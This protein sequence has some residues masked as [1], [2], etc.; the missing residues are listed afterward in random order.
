MMI[1]LL[2]WIGL[3]WTRLWMKALLLVRIKIGCQ[4]W[5]SMGVLMRFLVRIT[6]LSYV[7]AIYLGLTCWHPKREI[8]MLSMRV[9]LF[10]QYLL[11]VLQMF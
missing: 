8:R 9:R 2:V 7:A 1:L 6:A 10:S 4:I 5:T 3:V 11:L